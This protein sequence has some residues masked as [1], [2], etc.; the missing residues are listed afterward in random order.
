M[1]AGGGHSQGAR[2]GASAY[3]RSHFALKLRRTP[4]LS[5]LARVLPLRQLPARRASGRRCCTACSALRH[6]ADTVAWPAY[7]T[8]VVVAVVVRIA[9]VVD[10]GCATDTVAEQC[11]LTLASVAQHDPFANVARHAASSSPRAHLSAFLLGWRPAQRVKSP[12]R[13]DS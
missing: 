10:L 8:E 9:D 7:G 2:R 3:G 4:L 13:S 11:E 1:D 5:P 12:R 6:G